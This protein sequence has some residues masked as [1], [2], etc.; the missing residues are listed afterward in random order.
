L[1]TAKGFVAQAP[2]RIKV[3]K[4]LPAYHEEF[5]HF[6]ECIRTDKE[7]IVNGIEGY[8]TLEVTLAA[9][10]TSEK[11]MPVEIKNEGV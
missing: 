11:G 8:K 5:K 3:D 9:Y 2:T 4:N 6:F 1:F 10:D 7:P